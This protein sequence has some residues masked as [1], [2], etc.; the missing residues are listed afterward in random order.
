MVILWLGFLGFAIYQYK[1]SEPERPSRPGK[2][3]KSWIDLLL[4]FHKSQ[5][6]FSATLM[7]A[8]LNYGIYE[9]DM[10]VTFLLTPLATNSILPVIFA[11][12]LYRWRFKRGSNT[13]SPVW[14]RAFWFT[15]IV[16]LAAI[17]MQLNVLS[18]SNELNMIN[19]RGWTFGQI[20]AVTV[21]IPLLLEYIYSEMSEYLRLWPGC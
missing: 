4:E 18:I 9:V 11:Y 17:S 5:C 13:D 6:L 10:L 20:V 21:W 12:Q 7:I 1:R 15:T 3:Y 2:H 19:P 14:H 16:F 8:S